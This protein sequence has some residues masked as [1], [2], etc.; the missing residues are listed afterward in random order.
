MRKLKLLPLIITGILLFALFLP[1]L[2][3]EIFASRVDKTLV[4]YSPIEEDF[5]KRTIKSGNKREI[6]YSNMDESQKYK[7]E[8]FKTKLPF[9]YA[10]DLLKIEKFPQKYAAYATDPMQI[11]KETGFLRL[12]SKD[13]NKE[14][15]N[16]HILFE[17][18]PKYSS[19]EFPK[20]VFKIGG[21]GVVLSN[22]STNEILKEKSESYN[23]KLLALGATFPLKQAYGNP[24]TRKPFDEGYFITDS[25]NNLFHIKQIKGEAFV[26]KV[27]TNGIK[28]K[29]INHKEDSRKEYYALVVDENHQLYFMM[30]ET[31]DFIKLPIDDY[32]YKTHD[33]RMFA[34]P[35][36]RIFTVEYLKDDK[37]IINT[38]VTNLDY[39]LEKQ[40]KYTQSQKQDFA[41]ENIKNLL[42]P[43]TLKIFDYK[44]SYISFELVD[45]NKL[46]F[47][48]N[49]LIAFA[50]LIY[51]RKTKKA[52]KEHLVQSVLISL[53]GIYAL[54]VLFSLD[55]LKKG[56]K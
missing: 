46:A 36:N 30:Y 23:K 22:S 55:K 38:Y 6:I 7:H 27:E 1:K 33:F 41:Y 18:K 53:S 45:I 32:N 34:S 12:A 9:F 8:E 28:I 10:F 42:F 56:K 49:I 14:Y 40:N 29:Y 24:T 2:Y 39:E 19:L 11:R 54:L 21:N 26:K 5:I 20:E 44:E 35:I 43:F 25:K 51:I 3:K 31:Y 37:K 15:V 13:I 4:Y 50:Y 52:I 16:L 47:L 17:S 48:F